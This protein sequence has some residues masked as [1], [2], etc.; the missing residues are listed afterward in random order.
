M[1][2]YSDCPR[3]I[4]IPVVEDPRGNLAFIQSPGAC[5][6]DIER[7]YWIYDIPGHRERYG[8]ALRTT[9][10]LI[11]PLGGAFDVTLEQPGGEM[12]TYHLDRCDTGLYVPAGVWRIIDGF[13]S[14]SVVLVLA[15]RS[16]NPDDYIFNHAE[17]ALNYG[18]SPV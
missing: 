8:R 12:H 17:F 9:A 16:Y 13:A 3:L 11:V 14:N 10:E 1:E 2:K 15:D 7:V 6:F 4:H 18:C 5:P